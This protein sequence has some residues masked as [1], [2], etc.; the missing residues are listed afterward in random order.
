MFSF[1]PTEE[2]QLIVDTVRDFAREQLRPHS[3]G[4]NE[5]RTLPADV[6]ASARELGLIPANIPEA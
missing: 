1:H 6:L 5:S 4:A 3:H 2:Q